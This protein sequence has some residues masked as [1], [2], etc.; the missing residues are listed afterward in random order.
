M[1]IARRSV[2]RWTL[3]KIRAG[4]LAMNRQL[5]RCWLREGYDVQVGQ[6]LTLQGA[7]QVDASLRS[8]PACPASSSR[9]F[10]SAFSLVSPPPPTRTP[11]PV[12]SGFNLQIRSKITEDVQRLAVE[13]YL[14]SPAPF[15]RA[16]CAALHPPSPPPFLSFFFLCFPT[17]YTTLDRKR[18]RC[19]I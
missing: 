15:Q 19:C 8:R 6:R 3:R 4:R 1:V 17:P 7:L 10:S 11:P 12:L 5:C 13:I 16:L 9:L 2:S 18:C 14:S